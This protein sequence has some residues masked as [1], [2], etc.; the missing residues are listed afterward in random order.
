MPK[1]F[2]MIPTYNEALNILALIE[3]ILVL[4]V[5]NMH[6]LVVDDNSPDGTAKIVQSLL[7]NNKNIH[8]LLRIEN[9]GRGLA[10]IEGFKYALANGADIVIEMDADFSH[11]P[12]H[13]PALL[14]ALKMADVVLGSRFIGAGVDKREY[15]RRFLTVL[16]N[17]YANLILKLKLTDPNSGYRCYKRKVLELIIGDLKAIGADIVQDVIYNCNQHGFKI[18]EIPVEFKNRRLGETTKTFKDFVNGAI[19]CLRLRFGRQD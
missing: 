2:V 14:G 8:L 1:I 13:I 19:T 7:K 9:K 16:C 5:E 10:G 11:Q 12:K 4:G 17:L 18:S 6:V 3:E 15:K